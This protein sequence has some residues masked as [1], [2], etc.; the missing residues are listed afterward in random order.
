MSHSAGTLSS[1]RST[2]PRFF[3]I[4]YGDFGLFATLLISVAFGFMTFFAVTF[5]SIFSILIYNGGGHHALDLSS[6]YK[7]VALPAGCVV[8]AIALATLGSVWLRR[9]LTGR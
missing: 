5:V 4:P 9:R 1:T 2:G 8:L 3:G 7:Y 6:G